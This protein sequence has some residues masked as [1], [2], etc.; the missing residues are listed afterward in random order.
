MRKKIFNFIVLIFI[1]FNLVISSNL[2]FATSTEQ[3]LLTGGGKC[4]EIPLPFIDQCPSTPADYL[5]GLYKLALAIAV[6]AAVAM[7]TIAGIQYATSGDNASKQKE[8]RNQITD[9]IIGLIILLASVLILRTIN[10]D[11]VNLGK[12][13]P[14]TGVPKTEF[15][16]SQYEFE[17]KKTEKLKADCEKCKKECDSMYNPTSFKKLAADAE[18]GGINL[19]SSSTIEESKIKIEECLNICNEKYCL[20]GGVESE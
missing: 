8:A 19:S 6:I 13:L 17:E 20:E 5:S 15:N 12:W 16:W 10:P 1:F 3:W 11:L 4:L 7:I 9:A 14:P 2:V 18:S